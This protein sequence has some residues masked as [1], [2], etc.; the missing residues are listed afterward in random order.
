MPLA[1]KSLNDALLVVLFCV[2]RF[3]ATPPH[4]DLAIWAGHL[5]VFKQHPT[6]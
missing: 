4:S 5:V 2:A 1:M 6:S 3:S